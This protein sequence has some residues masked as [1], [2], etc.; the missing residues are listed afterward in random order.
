MFQDTQWGPNPNDTVQSLI[1][2]IKLIYYYKIY[3]EKVKVI[4]LNYMKLGFIHTTLLHLNIFLQSL[5]D[6]IDK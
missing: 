4:Q 1:D 6:L 2:K 3:D 5:L